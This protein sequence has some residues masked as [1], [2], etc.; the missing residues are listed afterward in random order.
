M[1][2]NRAAEFLDRRHAVTFQR[3][4]EGEVR[5]NEEPFVGFRAENRFHR[6]RRCAVGIPRPVDTSRRTG[7]AGKVRG[8]GA[9]QNDFVARARNLYDGKS[10]GGICDIR[11]YIDVLDIKPLAN[12]GRTDVRLVLVV[13]RKDFDA[14]AVDREAKLLRRHA[15]RLDRPTAGGAGKRSIHIGY[16]SDLNDA[17]GDLCV[18]WSGHAG[19][20]GKNQ[21]QRLWKP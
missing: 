17:V 1:A 13:R 20:D 3:M 2:D 8:S 21:V 10:D 7:L 18:G 16:D 15:C 6:T 11:H 19:R 9:D 4:P 14:P 12:D 5:A